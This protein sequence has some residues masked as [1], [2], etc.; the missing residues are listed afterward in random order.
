MKKFLVGTLLLLVF[1]ITLPILTYAQSCRIRGNR[2]RSTNYSYANYGYNQRRNYNRRNDE[3]RSYSRSY[4]QPSEYYYSQRRPSFYRR[5]R[6]LINIG[7]GSG[8][9]AL[10]GGLLGGRRGA[11][12]GLLAGA[13]TS[14]LYTYKI[15]P[16]QR[17]YYR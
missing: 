13:G 6:N 12:Y 16:K 8:A 5:H 17:R 9:G 11:G 15:R 14:A 3:R 7:I 2:A 10:I 4:Y 1:A